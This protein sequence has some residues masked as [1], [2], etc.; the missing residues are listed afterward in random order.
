MKSGIGN[1]DI[2]SCKILFDLARVC[3]SLSSF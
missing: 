3:S 2:D 1:T